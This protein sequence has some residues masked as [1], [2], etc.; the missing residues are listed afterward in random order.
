[1]DKNVENGLEGNGWGRRRQEIEGYSCILI[2]EAHKATNLF[3]EKS[4]DHQKTSLSHV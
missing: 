1:M 2:H 4:A 3:L